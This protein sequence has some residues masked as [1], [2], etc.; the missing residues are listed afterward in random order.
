[1]DGVWRRYEPPRKPFGFK[2]G[3]RSYRGEGNPKKCARI[4]ESEARQPQLPCHPGE[5][6]LSGVK[7]L[8]LA[9]PPDGRV[10]WGTCFWQG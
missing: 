3:G 7:S 9:S 10:E 8:P 1:M 2:Y 5:A 6:L 4:R